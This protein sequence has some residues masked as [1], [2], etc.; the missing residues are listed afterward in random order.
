MSFERPLTRSGGVA[1]DVPK[2]MVSRQKSTM[3][4]SKIAQET[5][6]NPAFLALSKLRR[7]KFDE[8]IQICDEQLAQNPRDEAVWFIK[9]RALTQKNYIDDMDMEEEG[10]A[11]VLLD[12]N[13]M[14]KQPRPGTSLRRP[15]TGQQS[16]GGGANQAVRP[17]TGSGRPQSGFARPG[18]QSRG[19]N[20][21]VD[22]AFSGSRPGTSRP[23]SVAGRF[24]RLGTASIQASAS[25]AFIESERLDFKKQF[26][27]PALA[28]ALCDYLLYVERNTKK[29]LELAAE[30]TKLSQ[31]K[32]WWWKAR[33]GK[34]YYQLGMFRDAE[35]QFKS[36]LTHEEIIAV[37]LELAKVYLR[38]DQPN[39]ALEVYNKASLTF[40]GDTSLYIGTARVYDALNDMA[41]GT[42]FYKK[43]LRLDSTNVEA[44]ACLASQLFYSDQP[45]VAVRYYRRLLQTGVN[46]TEM[47]NNLGLCCFYSSQ[48]DITL[49][50]LERA[51][52][53]AGDDN[54]ADVWYN[55]GQV[56]VGIGDLNLAFQAFKIA[57][58]CDSKHPESFNNLGILELRNGNLDTAKS[59]FL[60]AMS[61]APHVFEPHF[62]AALV[63]NRV[64]DLQ[65][66][67]DLV[68]KSLAAFP[69]HTDSKELLNTLRK[70]FTKL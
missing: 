25:G 3:I 45:E 70:F 49:S 24:V 2:E 67:F 1:I 28:K 48:Y 58:T 57:L 53:M 10:V 68:S 11:E 40:P 32:D 54:M 36:A 69:E 64:G 46:N 27:K 63:A 65:D 14:A 50:C 62:N 51:L 41:T 56:A 38:L 7:R 34:C 47:W 19:V 20:V 35:R 22:Q 18:T 39:A 21:S 37:Y 12:E 42:T 61:I 23:M 15:L 4:A 6:I 5:T 55:I 31:F 9:C 13:A 43:V 33:L 44:M 16:S 60:S 66:S 29:A 59:H 30:Q 26:T 17:M 8:A 52:A